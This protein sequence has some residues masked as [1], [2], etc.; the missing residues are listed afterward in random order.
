MQIVVISLVLVGFMQECSCFAPTLQKFPRMNKFG[1]I[2]QR[3]P[4]LRIAPKA[5]LSTDYY[6]VMAAATNLILA[7]SEGAEAEVDELL[8][9]VTDIHL[10]PKEV[11]EI[12]PLDL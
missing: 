6:N 9:P 5:H 8:S 1:L 10:Y 11:H 3:R 2:S 4:L 12:Y 7:H